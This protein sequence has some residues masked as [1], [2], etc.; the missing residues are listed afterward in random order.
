MNW[1]KPIVAVGTSVL[2][3]VLLFVPSAQSI[4]ENAIS[5]ITDSTVNSLIPSIWPFEH[6]KCFTVDRFDPTFPHCL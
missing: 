2:A 5:T 6:G 1:S 4:A 3:T